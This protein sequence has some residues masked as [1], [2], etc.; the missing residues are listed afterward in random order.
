MI[1]SI[2]SRRNLCKKVF[3]VSKLGTKSKKKQDAVFIGTDCIVKPTNWA[4]PRTCVE[5]V[6]LV[7]FIIKKSTMVVVV[8]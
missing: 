7:D 5:G 1:K 6:Y 2:G 4:N 8:K 3:N